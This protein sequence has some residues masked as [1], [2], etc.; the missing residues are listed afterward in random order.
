MEIK[1]DRA[2]SESR[3]RCEPGRTQIVKWT[4]EGAMKGISRVFR[5][6]KA[7]VSCQ[8]YVS[9]LIKRADFPQSEVA[10]RVK[11]LRPS[12]TI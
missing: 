7:Y 1:T 2:L 10:P 6:E 4:T 8:E 5:D 11:I 9:I 3:S 12:L